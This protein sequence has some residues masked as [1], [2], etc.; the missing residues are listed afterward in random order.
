MVGGKSDPVTIL[1]YTPS[2]VPVRTVHT[3]LIAK[4]PAQTV[5]FVCTA[6]HAHVLI[7]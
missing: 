1:M 6:I 3:I 4:S 2:L 5:V 7:I